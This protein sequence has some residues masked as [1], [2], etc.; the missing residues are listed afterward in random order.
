[1][2][3][4]TPCTFT[5][6]FN[7]IFMTFTWRWRPTIDFIH[8]PSADQ[9]YTKRDI[10]LTVNTRY[11]ALT[12]PRF[13]SCTFICGQPLVGGAFLANRT[14]LQRRAQSASHCTTTVQLQAFGVLCTLPSVCI[15]SGMLLLDFSD[16]TVFLERGR[17]FPLICAIT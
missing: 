5:G 6:W 16:F 15:I 7:L 11:Y 2:N 4:E 10:W 13:I 9:E 17:F 1:M 3:A 12:I 8:K 14:V